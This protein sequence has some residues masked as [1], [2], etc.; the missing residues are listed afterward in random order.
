MFLF[1][2]ITVVGCYIITIIDLISL[3]VVE[4]S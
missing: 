3:P 2:F 4:T 1:S